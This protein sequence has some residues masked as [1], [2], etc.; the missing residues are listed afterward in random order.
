MLFANRDRTRQQVAREITGKRL[1]E[2][3]SAWVCIFSAFCADGMDP[4]VT[5]FGG[6]RGGSLLHQPFRSAHDIAT[7]ALEATGPERIQCAASRVAATATDVARARPVVYSRADER[8]PLPLS[9]CQ[10]V[11]CG[12]QMRLGTFVGFSSC[13][14]DQCSHPVLSPSHEQSAGV[15]S[16]SCFR[17]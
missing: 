4:P 8:G 1:A 15:L 13:L 5:A 17:L 14:G 6:R 10:H 11:C 7:L 12:S 3:L 2:A 16:R 9:T